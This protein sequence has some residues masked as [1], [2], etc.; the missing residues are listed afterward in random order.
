MYYEPIMLQSKIL[1]G[2]CEKS[3]DNLNPEYPK[4]AMDL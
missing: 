1:W 2:Q 3:L 4:V